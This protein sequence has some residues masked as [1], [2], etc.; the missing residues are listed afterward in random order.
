MFVVCVRTT[1]PVL[2]FVKEKQHLNMTRSFGD[3]ALT[4]SIYNY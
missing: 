4:V 3:Y 1:P 2:P